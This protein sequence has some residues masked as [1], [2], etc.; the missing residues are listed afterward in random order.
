MFSY[1]TYTSQ[2]LMFITE[3]TFR[4]NGGTYITKK[5][6]DIIRP[7]KIDTRTEEEVINKISTGLNKL[8]KN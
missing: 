7:E 3:N 4:M 8:G 5:W 2:A 6:N 1:R